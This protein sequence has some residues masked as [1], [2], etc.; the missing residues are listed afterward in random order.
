M[1]SLISIIT[2]EAH[3]VHATALVHERLSLLAV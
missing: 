1:L 3:E 2:S